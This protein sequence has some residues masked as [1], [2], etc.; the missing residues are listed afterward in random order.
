MRVRAGPRPGP[1]DRAATARS[2][3]EAPVGC[4]HAGG[5][6]FTP[7]RK[8]SPP[9]EIGRTVST[10]GSDPS[11]KGGSVSPCGVVQ[12]F[13]ADRG[14][15]LIS[16]EGAEPDVQAEASAIHGKERY[17]RP[18]EEVFFDITLDGAGLRADNIHRPPGRGPQPLNRSS[19]ATLHAGWP[20]GQT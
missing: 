2:S 20:A 9:V 15:G 12:W 8:P 17:L 11:G 3:P 14:I 5:R 13:D 4:S 16:Q 7:L 18:G 6:C 1:R 19:T 10:C